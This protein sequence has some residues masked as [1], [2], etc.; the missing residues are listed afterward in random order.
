MMR[1]IIFLVIGVCYDTKEVGI[2]FVYMEKANVIYRL[3]DETVLLKRPGV[4]VRWYELENEKLG[5]S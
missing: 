2:H 4:M 3:S 5:K 1:F